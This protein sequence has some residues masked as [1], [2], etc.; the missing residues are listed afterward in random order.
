M[1]YTSN[2]QSNGQAPLIEVSKVANGWLV[3]VHHVNRDTEISPETEE[4]RRL[5]KE[6]RDKKFYEEEIERATKDLT[7]QLASVTLIGEIA[8]KAQAKSLEDSFEPW[9]DAEDLSEEEL[10]EKIKPVAAK[11]AKQVRPRRPEPINF[12]QLASPFK[13]SV[14]AFVFVDREEMI[15]FVSE[16]LQPIVE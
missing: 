1:L 3:V 14:E 8:A 16:M 10:M 7:A 2:S 4:K 9:K 6:E 15:K 12:S 11:I 13:G 5:E